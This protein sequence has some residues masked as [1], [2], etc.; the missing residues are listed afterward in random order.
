[1]S[2]F[3]ELVKGYSG[4]GIFT[5]L[6][7]VGAAAALVQLLGCH[8]C[9]RATVSVERKKLYYL[10]W[11][12]MMALLALLAF[13]VVALVAAVLYWLSATTAFQVGP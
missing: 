1:V 2:E 8:V 5:V 9:F 10:L 6:M 11:V 12:Y 7:A 13:F 4:G 3:G